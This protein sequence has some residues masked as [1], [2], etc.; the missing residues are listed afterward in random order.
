M[1]VNP[2]S[3]KILTY[4]KICSMTYVGQI[5]NG[6][7]KICTKYYKN[8]AAQ[9][10]NSAASEFTLKVSPIMPQDKAQ[11]LHCHYQG[12]SSLPPPTGMYEN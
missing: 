12:E 9:R 4:F 5:Y 2:V 10:I 11:I 7:G 3:E 8:V 1:H 6:E